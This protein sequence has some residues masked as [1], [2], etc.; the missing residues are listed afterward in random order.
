M[1]IDVPNHWMQ[2]A[3]TRATHPRKITFV[4]DIMHLPDIKI[5]CELKATLK[6]T[7]DTIA[8]LRHDYPGAFFLYDFTAKSISRHDML[9]MPLKYDGTSRY[10]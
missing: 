9:R 10:C 3:N 4:D 6:C 8:V 1:S 7:Q 2:R 5:V